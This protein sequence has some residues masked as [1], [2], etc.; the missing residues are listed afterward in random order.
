MISLGNTEY[1]SLE[2]YKTIR[3]EQEV[4]GTYLPVGFIISARFIKA[5]PS[6]SCHTA[7]DFQGAPII[8]FQRSNYLFSM[9]EPSVL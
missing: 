6:L 3:A 7:R 1:Y 5:F 9:K 8:C 2:K 4:T